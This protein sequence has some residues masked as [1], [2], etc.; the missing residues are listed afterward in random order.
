MITHAQK[1]ELTE[2]DGIMLLQGRRENDE[3]FFVYMI[4]SLEQI[5]KLEKDSA[6]GATVDFTEYGEVIIAGTGFPMTD[7]KAY[8]EKEYNFK[9]LD[10]EPEAA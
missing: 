9:H 7:H 3:D 2:N 5:E 1:A 10:D 4:M 6:E 8:M